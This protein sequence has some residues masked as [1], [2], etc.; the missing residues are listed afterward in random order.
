V[1]FSGYSKA[2]LS[3]VAGGTISDA[4]AG[5]GDQSH[6]TVRGRG[7]TLLLTLSAKRA[8]E[9]NFASFA[10]APLPGAD[11]T[12]ES[13]LHGG[14]AHAEVA[15]HT[16]GTRTRIKRQRGEQVLGA[17]LA[18][19]GGSR[20]AAHGARRPGP[21]QDQP[22]GT[23]YRQIAGNLRDGKLPPPLS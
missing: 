7:K 18:A 11:V 16:P 14:D 6:L 2:L 15:E 19:P 12:V 5:P 21:W 17:H 4:A 8:G 9:I 10:A 3:A 23:I 22:P 1:L 13:L 20:L